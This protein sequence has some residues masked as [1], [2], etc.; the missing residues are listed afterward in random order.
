MIDDSDS[1]ISPNTSASD[2]FKKPTKD[3][4]AHISSKVKTHW[5]IEEKQRHGIKDFFERKS[6]GNS[7]NSSMNNS[8]TT[9]PNTSLI[10]PNPNRRSLPVPTKIDPVAVAIAQIKRNT[11]FYTFS[12]S[13]NSSTSMSSINEAPEN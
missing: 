5:S 7:A 11:R 8:A 12:E 3:K 1:K 10:K 6:G 9:S 4:Y 13:A 2:E